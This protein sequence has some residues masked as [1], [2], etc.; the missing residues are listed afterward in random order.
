MKKKRKQAPGA[1]STRRL[2][3]F[4]INSFVHFFPS[5]VV[6]FLSDFQTLLKVFVLTQRQVGADCSRVKFGVPVW[7]QAVPGRTHTSVITDTVKATQIQAPGEE[8]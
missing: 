1:K 2:S 7:R 4:D 8:D 3:T 5:A 6:C